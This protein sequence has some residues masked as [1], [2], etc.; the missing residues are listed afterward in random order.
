V[1]PTRSSLLLLGHH[2]AQRREFGSVSG[3]R[4]VG[5]SSRG[6]GS[7]HSHR[8]GRSE[9]E[10]G[11]ARCVR[12]HGRLAKEV[13]AL[14]GA[15]E[16]GEELDREDLVRGDVERALDRGPAGDGLGYGSPIVMLVP[17]RLTHRFELCLLDSPFKARSDAPRP[18]LLCQQGLFAPPSPGVA[19]YSGTC[20]PL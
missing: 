4:G 8:Q 12:G 3:S 20:R 18:D 6:Y 16:V 10:R 13:L 1:A 9:G 14:P 15:F 7:P 11:I 2:P 19:C 5:S 17:F